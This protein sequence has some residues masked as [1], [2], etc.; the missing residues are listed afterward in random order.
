[1]AKLYVVG[2]GPGG[3]EHLTQRAI[4]VLKS[5]DVITGYIYY[6][7][8][9]K[10]F[11]AGKEIIKTG[12]T[13]EVERCRLAISEVQ[14][15]KNTCI[16]STG[17]AGL[18]G[19]AGPV[20]ELAEDIEI[21]VVPGVSSV[22]AAAAELGAP[23]MHDMCTISLSDLLTPWEVIVKRI[24]LAAQGDFVISLYN[25]KSKGR[26]EHLNKAIQLIKPYFESDRPVALVKN[27]ARE[28]NERKLV[29]L[30]TIDYDFV[31][32]RTVVIIGNSQTFIKQ[33]KMVTPR[34]YKI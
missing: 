6:I 4:E 26:K 24:E 17:D 29:T 32:M 33:G 28:G 15:G 25:P 9:I 11:T 2:V 31:D 27:A 20:F 10:E 3:K 16:I 22:F 12:M 18:Y 14:N 19:M 7:N 23:L 34:G 8:L 1:M 5:C 30:D 13:H 21:E